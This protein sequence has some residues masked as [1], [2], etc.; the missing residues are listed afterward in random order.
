MVETDKIQRSIDIISR[1]SSI[2]EEGESFD[3]ISE[4]YDIAVD[5]M[6]R[7]IPKMVVIK[8]WSPAC[9]P[10]CGRELSQHRGDGWYTHPTFLERCTDVDCVQKLQWPEGI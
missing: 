3:E 9:C 2:P 5:I 10:R 7:E 4:A 1:K 8:D 6:S